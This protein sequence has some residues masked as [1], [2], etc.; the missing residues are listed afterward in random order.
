MMSSLFGPTTAVVTWTELYGTERE[1]CEVATRLLKSCTVTTRRAASDAQ[2]SPNLS[3]C[4]DYD[5]DDD[6]GRFIKQL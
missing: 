2:S 6:E 5:D 1:T 4:R 3:G